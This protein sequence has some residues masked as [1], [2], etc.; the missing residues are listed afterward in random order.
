[1]AA[2]GCNTTV[3]GGHMKR[4]IIRAALAA[5]SMILLAGAAV[6]ITMGYLHESQSVTNT[7]TVG[8]LSLGLKETDWDE[9]EGDGRQVCPG[10]SAYKNPTLKNTTPQKEGAG[11]C[12]ARMCIT[13][14]DENGKEIT[15]GEALALIKSTIRYDDT[16]SGTYEKKGEGTKITQGRI[17]GYT[18]QELEKLPMINPL[19]EID[20]KRSTAGRIVCNYM[21][22]AGDGLLQIGEEKVLFTDIAVPVHWAAEEMEKVGNFR[23]NVS[24]EAIQSA[25]FAGQEQAFSAL[26]AET[27]GQEQALRVLDAKTGGR[28]RS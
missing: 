2:D 1:M 12:Y 14:C 19:F 6:G 16:Y 26:D 25:G 28:E 9:T 8:E 11:P 17:P 24:A 22:Q 15:D 18:L 7:F 13:I 3:K 10:Y 21:G 5:G 20:Q 27:G 4:K 23:I